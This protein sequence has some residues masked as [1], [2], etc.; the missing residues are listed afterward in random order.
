MKLTIARSALLRLVASCQGVAEEKSALQA[1][2]HVLLTAGDGTLRIC[3]TDTI[4]SADGSCA[5]DVKEQGSVALK[6]RE[7][8]TRV[9]AMPDGDVSFSVTAGG[10]TIIKASGGARKFSMYGLNGSDYPTLFAPKPD[11]ITIDVPR[12]ALS[13]LLART[14]FAACKDMN[15]PNVNAVCLEFEDREIRAVATDGHRISKATALANFGNN[16]AT[17]VVPLKAVGTVRGLIDRSTVETIAITISQP[18]ALFKIDDV[19]IGAKLTDAAFPP[20]NQVIPKKSDHRATVQRSAL[21]D[22]ISAVSL[23][24]GD[25]TSGVHVTLAAGFVR[26]EGRSAEK[27]NGFDEVPS[28]YEGA[29]VTVGLNAVYV[30]EVLKALDSAD[31]TI[32][33]TGELDPVVITPVGDDQFI[34]VV[35]PM[36][37]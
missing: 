24:A 9:K 29:E 19:T 27:G 26:I 18:W 10:E 23:A 15:R 7:L 13:E 36:R 2:S 20:Y 31:V 8:F 28:D 1:L 22:A 17:L 32:G 11:A 4:V 6:A 25:R 5:A 21:L 3:A 33:V 16:D 12:V 35:M 14:D 30:E 34:A 37:I